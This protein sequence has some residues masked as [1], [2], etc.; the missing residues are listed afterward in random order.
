MAPL[1]GRPRPALGLPGPRSQLFQEPAP[2]TSRL[3]PAPG[4][5][6]CA[7]APSTFRPTLAPR[8]LT[9]QPGNPGHGSTNQW[10]ST[11][12]RNPWAPSQPCHDLALP[13]NGPEP[14]LPWMCHDLT[15]TVSSC[16]PLCTSFPGNQLDHGPAIPTNAPIVVIQL[17]QKDPRSPHG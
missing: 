2:T 16:Q 11:S 17:K 8:T 3:T 5:L 9:L 4:P 13:T 15:S 12:P 14:R 6:L 1:T 7:I 10:A